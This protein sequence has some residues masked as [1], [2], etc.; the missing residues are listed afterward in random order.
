MINREKYIAQIRPF[1]ESDLIKVIT[2]IRRCGKS[3]VLEQIKNELAAQG[4]RIIYLNF[5]DRRVSASITTDLELTE[6]VENEL[7]PYHNEKLYVFLDEVQMVK[8]WNLACRSLRLQNI[9][10]FI[11]GSNSN[12]LSREFTKELSGRYVSFTIRPFVY[13]EI[14]EYAK[15]LGRKVS[16]NDY[17]VYG[18]FPKRF[19]FPG[20][21]EM[22]RY[23]N[24]LDETI[25]LNDIINRHNIRKQEIFKKLVNYVL[26]SN[27]RI[28]SSNSVHRYL[29]SQKT[30][31]SINTVMKYIDYLEEAYVVRKLPQYSTKAKKQLEFYTKLYDE[32]VMFNS[33]RQPNNRFDITH[34]LENVVYN[35]L[36]YMGYN[37]SVYNVNDKEIDFW[38]A[39]N[40]REYLIQ[41]AYSVV[42]ESTYKREFAGFNELDNSRKKIL[43]TNDEND[44]STST[45]LHIRLKDFLMLNDLED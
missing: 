39:K 32:D 16:V 23:L 45:V 26:V 13:K 36:V 2:G 33:I 25:V 28:F 44:F 19:E 15:E 38:A 10:L 1:Y 3:V 6:H 9:S 24:D 42:E 27:A 41:V 21:D 17:L 18:G 31:C 4:K 22:L 29:K 34:N 43:I 35:E 14:V 12:L 30:D 20:Q 37:L 8:N 7:S 11:T 40:G 5:E